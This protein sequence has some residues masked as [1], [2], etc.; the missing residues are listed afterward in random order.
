MKIILSEVCD[1]NNIKIIIILYFNG[2]FFWNPCF[3]FV[4]C[5]CSADH[6]LRNNGRC[7]DGRL[8][9]M[10]SIPGRPWLLPSLVSNWSKGYLLWRER[11]RGVK[12]LP[13]GIKKKNYK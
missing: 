4:K 11:C 1:N 6:H 12:N 2:I 5:G 7:Y 8:R 10:V 9:G 13:G 3:H